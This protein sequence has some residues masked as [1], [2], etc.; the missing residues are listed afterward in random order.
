MS[1]LPFLKFPSIGNFKSLMYVCN[2][3]PYN[4]LEHDLYIHMRP[5]TKLHGTNAAVRIY[6]GDNLVTAQS[7][8]RKLEIGNDNFGFAAWVKENEKIFL[9]SYTGMTEHCYTIFGE[10]AGKGIQKSDAISKTDRAFHVFMVTVQDAT[11]KV[12]GCFTSPEEIEDLWLYKIVEEI[13]NLHVIPWAGPELIINASNTELNG[14]EINNINK[15]V[16]MCSERCEYTFKHFGIEE[17]GEGFVY[18]STVFEGDIEACAASSP[19]HAKDL[20]AWQGNFMFKAK[21]EN[22]TVEKGSKPAAIDP[23]VLAQQSD[24]TQRFCTDARLA[25]GAKEVNEG[26]EDYSRRETGKFIAWVCSDVHKETE[27]EREEAEVN[28]K[29]ISKGIATYARR[30]YL[31]RA[32]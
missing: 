5:R 22:H 28:W 18:Y 1:E 27:H 32:M 29:A 13:D 17:G 30:W 23:L 16:E 12:L 8:N 24:F 4:H 20:L 7:R 9:Y 2:K 19:I 31:E 11:G 15:M 3:L 14:P 21:G 26:S 6:P 25:Q 10:W